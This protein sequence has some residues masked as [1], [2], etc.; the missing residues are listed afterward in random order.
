MDYKA[1]FAVIKRVHWNCS[2]ISWLQ[3]PAEIWNVQVQGIQP[4]SAG[5]FGEEEKEVN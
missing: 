4:V 2:A 1:A 3:I 5:H